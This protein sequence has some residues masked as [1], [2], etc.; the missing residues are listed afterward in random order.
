MNTPISYS[1]S[2]NQVRNLILGYTST[3]PDEIN[4]LK[5]GIK[6][7]FTTNIYYKSI[8]K[9]LDENSNYDVW[10]YDGKNSG[11]FKVKKFTSYP[12]DTVQFNLGDY[13]SY[14]D[15]NNTLQVW[16]ITTIDQTNAF[17]VN[18]EIQ[19]CVYNLKWQNALGVIKQC[20][21]VFDKASTMGLTIT[22]EIRTFD[23]IYKL[24]MQLNDD[25]KLLREDK[26]FIADVSGVDIPNT[27]RITERN[28]ITQYYDGNGAIL[29]LTLIKDQFRENEGDNKEFMIANYFNPNTPPTPSGDTNYSVITCSNTANQISIGSSRTLTA[30]F[31][32]DKD[33]ILN[34]KTASWSYTY[35]NGYQ[36]Q[37]TIGNSETNKISIKVADNS[38]LIGKTF[39]ASVSDGNGGFVS[40]ITIKIVG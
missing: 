35:P 16:L 2:T 14:I 6:D 10:I 31:Y 34:N 1:P 28:P 30:T 12:Y 38:D 39:V 19:Q 15:D 36:N 11:G 7:G 13:I 22:E 23:S 37:F 18:G 24:K 29:N 26:R 25:T 8:H 9:N 4:Q 32:A 33:T 20:W 3:L 27:Y 21:C 17:E 5:D 40:S